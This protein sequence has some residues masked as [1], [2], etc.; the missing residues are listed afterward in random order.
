M[1]KIIS[2]I[3]GIFFAIIQ[4]MLPLTNENISIHIRISIAALFA[5]VWILYTIFSDKID[6]IICRSGVGRNLKNKSKDEKL[7]YFYNRIMP[8]VSVVQKAVI[9]DVDNDFT[10][11]L[12]Y[13][14]WCEAID[15][16]AMDC[17]TSEKQIDCTLISF[18]SERYAKTF[19]SRSI[20]IDYL[21]SI[22]DVLNSFLKENNEK[23][24][25]QIDFTTYSGRL[26][27]IESLIK[28]NLS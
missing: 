17:C 13:H 14:L 25:E 21:S 16:I 20:N 4:A 18:G 9:K 23:I 10:K 12:Y 22:I 19:R 26:K 8:N 6:A 3:I 1:R 27:S 2:A 15:F 5:G 24:N 7:D 28:Q 11:N